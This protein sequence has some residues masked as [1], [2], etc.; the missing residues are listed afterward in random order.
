ME[1]II[2]WNGIIKSSTYPFY[3]DTRIFQVMAIVLHSSTNTH[4]HVLIHMYIHTYIHTHTTHTH[5]NKQTH[6]HKIQVII[7]NLF[8]YNVLMDIWSFTS[9]FII[10]LDKH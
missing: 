3:Y 4:A 1:L 10:L 8:T 9:T 6:I 2:S 5:T 7:K